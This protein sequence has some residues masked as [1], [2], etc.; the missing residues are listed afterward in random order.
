M[1]QFE[2]IT[3]TA[4]RTRYEHYEFL[5]IPFGLTNVPAVFMDL[6]N[7]VFRPY[8]DQFIITFINDILIYSRTEEERVKHLQIALPTLRS[9]YLYA[10]F[11]QSEFSLYEVKFLGHV[12]NENEISV[13]SSKVDAILSWID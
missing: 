1:V 7:R 6:I 10:K 9:N 2:D 5:V 8:L 4:F 3:K 13:D 11:I 12:I